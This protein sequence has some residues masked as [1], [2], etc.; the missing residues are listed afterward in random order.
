MMKKPKKRVVQQPPTPDPIEDIPENQ[1]INQKKIAFAQSA[2]IEAVITLLKECGG[3][4]KL[5]GDSEYQTVVNAV[6]LDA[7][8]EM[9]TKFIGMVDSIKRGSLHSQK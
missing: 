3:V 2:H 7:Q 5:V 9:I 1:T 8:Q 4:Q 6:T